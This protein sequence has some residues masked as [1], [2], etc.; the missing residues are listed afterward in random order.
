M[1]LTQKEMVKEIYQTLNQLILNAEILGPILFDEEFQEEVNAL[2]KTQESLMAHF[3]H[4]QTMLYSVYQ[5]LMKEEDFERKIARLSQLN[6][7]ITK[8]LS[9]KKSHKVSSIS[10]K[11]KIGRNRLSK[12]RKVS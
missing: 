11:V 4:M 10:S 6:Q 2:M 8:A 9:A 1:L 3:V 7:Y 5:K 12:A